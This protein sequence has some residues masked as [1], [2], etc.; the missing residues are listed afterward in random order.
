MFKRKSTDDT[1]P[2][3]EALPLFLSSVK[4]VWELDKSYVILSFFLLII[5]TVPDIFAAFATAVF[6]Q[7]IIVGAEKYASY[8]YVYYPLLISFFVMILYGILFSVWRWAETK[9]MDKITAYLL[10]ES[11]KKASMLDYSSYDDPEFYDRIQKGWSQDGTM[12]IHSATTVFNSISYLLG[13]VAYISVLAYVDWKL[14][15]AITVIRMIVN[16]FINKTYRMIYLLD[17]KLA[18]LRRKE[19]YYRGFFNEKGMASEGKIFNL[20]NYAKENYLKAHKAIY[21]ATFIHKIK[22]NGI[23]LLSNIIYNFPLAAGYIY[24]SICVYNGTVSLA[25]MTLFISMYVGFVDQVYNTISNI[26]DLRYYAEQSRYAREFM[27]L[28]TG[29]FTDYDHTKERVSP[30]S[31]GH[32]IDFLNVTFRYP[33]TEKNVLENVSFRVEANECVSI[34]GANGAGKTTLIH[35]LMRLYDPTDGVIL[36]DGRDLRDYSA[37]SL[38]E[39]Y[40]VLFQDYCNYAV[41][42]KESITLSIEDILAER[43]NNSLRASTAYKFIDTLE[44]GRDTILSRAFDPKGR[45][46]SVGQKQ[47]IAIA[48]AYY[49]DAPVIILDEPSASI[50]PE[51]ESEILDSVIEMK[52]KK[53]IWLI[54]H[55]LSTCVFS[56]RVLLLKDGVLIGNGT[57]NELLSTNEEY[58]RMFRLQADRYEVSK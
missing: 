57:H 24:L 14:M 4:R 21:K 13:M 10:R 15:V 50:D 53:N 20:Y 48:R 31:A 58:K 23:N 38:Y 8:L 28:P 42:A 54:S 18:E 19:Q 37:E 45:E 52:G 36:L 34:I 29:I 25:N 40:G 39:I 51:S 1:I 35:L 47:R 41:S 17:N 5:G 30:V 26:S 7:R 55:R 2:F 16:P 46:L 27:T 9:S 44:K 3:R 6:N 49:K 33:D 56:D 12:F 32:T 43:F 11:V 22:V